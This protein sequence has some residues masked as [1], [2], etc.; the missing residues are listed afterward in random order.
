MCTSSKTYLV[1]DE[2][3]AQPIIDAINQKDRLIT[4]RLS[5]N[6]LAPDGAKA[7]A[8]ALRDR[9]ELQHLL[10]ADI[11]TGRLK[12]EIPV[13]I[14]HL[15]DALNLGEGC[16]LRTLDLSDNAFGPN[17][18]KAVE[19]WL[20]TKCCLKLVIIKTGKKINQ[21]LKANFTAQ[22]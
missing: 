19:P 4:L 11:F 14:Q 10:L 22:Q 3:D 20:R 2:T 16:R 12:D 17:G 13:A 18:A 8:L 7:I 21:C 5:G 9:N 15:N 1:N 6:T